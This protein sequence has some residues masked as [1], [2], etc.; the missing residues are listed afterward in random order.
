VPAAELVDALLESSKGRHLM[1]WSSRPEL[2]DVW[3]ELHT[4]GQLAPNGLMVSFQNYAANKLDWYLRPEAAL[5]VALAPN[6]D[7]R[8]RLTMVMDVPALDELSDASPYILGPNPDRQGLFLTAHLPAAAYDITTTDER[9]FKTKGTDG[10]MQVRTFLVDVPAGTTVE[11][12]IEFTLPRDHFGVV[13]LP[14]ARLEPMPL[15]VDGHTTVTDA[16][17][18]FV[19]W[20]AA[21][22]TVEVADGVRLPVRVLVTVGLLLTVVATGAATG[23]LVR[24]GG[25]RPRPRWLVAAQTTA[26]AALVAFVAAGAMAVVLEVP[27]V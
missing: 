25:A 7:Y 26:V 5:D 22:A 18:R 20:D 8:A 3:E 10:P 27:R 4:A 15:T 13:L 12:V 1:L 16:E 24:R 9:G 2:Q 14:S 23:S 19:M 6:G 21:L 17:P 11:R